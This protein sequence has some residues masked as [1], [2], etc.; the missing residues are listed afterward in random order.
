SPGPRTLPQAIH[1][2]LRCLCS[3]KASGEPPKETGGPNE[4]KKEDSRPEGES[5]DQQPKGR[6]SP[7]ASGAPA[8]PKSQ[9]ESDD[10][11]NDAEEQKKEEAEKKEME[12]KG[13]KEKEKAPEAAWYSA[14]AQST[15]V[16]QKHG[17]FHAPYTGPN[18]LRENEQTATSRT[19]KRFLDVRLW[20]CGS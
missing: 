12:E 13:K 6:K 8:S 4:A 2:Y 1:A 11:K 15:V 20:D 9:P 5:G 19:G 3:P 14:H 17:G 7:A 16:I 18:S 10:K